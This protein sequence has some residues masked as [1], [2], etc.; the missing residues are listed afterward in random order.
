MLFRGRGVTTG[1]KTRPWRFLLEERQGRLEGELR[2]LGWSDSLEMNAWFE[3]YAGKE[4]EVV[5][6]D[7][8]RAVLNPKGVRYHE[9]GHHSESSVSVQG[10][11]AFDDGVEV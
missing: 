3:K 2:A 1:E 9:T 7:L 4:V 5:L 10:Y 8:G 6:G 11:L